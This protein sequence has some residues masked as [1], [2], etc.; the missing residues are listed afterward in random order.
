MAKKKK[1]DSNKPKQVVK[2]RKVGRPKKRGRKK[3]YYQPKKKSKK[4]AK[5]GF[6]KNV[7]YNRVRSILWTNFKDDFPSYRS[8][9]SNQKDE[10]GNPIKGTSIVSQV[11][12]Q[13]KD[14]DCLDSDIIEIYNQF[15]NQQP[16]EKDRPVLPN[17]YFDTHYYWTLLTEDWWSGFD[18]RIWVEAPMLLTDPDSFLGILGSDRYVDKDGEL[19]NRKF[20]SKKGD[21]IIGG[22]AQRFN[23]FVNHCN[24]L[25]TEGY[26]SSSSNVPHWRFTG[27][28]EEL[29]DTEVYWNPFKKRWEIKIVICE[30]TGDI[31]SYDFD[32]REP[33]A[34]IDEDLINSIL[35]KPKET[36]TEQPIEEPEE[37]KDKL[38]KEE[39]E[40]KKKELEQED[41]RIKIEEEKQEREKEKSKRKDK[42]LER[43][44][45]GKIDEDKF[46]EMLK[47]I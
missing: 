11:F 36:P 47:L 43:Y 4:V 42:L 39:I 34:E 8:F 2:K 26:I 20:D 7:T 30:P 13:C 28:S 21:Y 40:L 12:A 1:I 25:Q 45:E 23:E 46:L 37:P 14:L 29:D 9:I 44:L 38:S 31:E 18:S 17:D 5:K 24:D 27:E 19:I 15:K 35:N 32:P 16:D 33:D 6:S 10:Q 41:K 22:K 3:I